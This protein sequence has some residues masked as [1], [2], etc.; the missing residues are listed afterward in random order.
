[1]IF[2]F[3]HRKLHFHGLIREVG[4]WFLVAALLSLFAAPFEPVATAQEPKPTERVY[5][6][7]QY[8][9]EK[10][11]EDMHAYESARLPVLAGFVNAKANTLRDY[12]NPHYQF[13]IDVIGQGSDHTLV[14]VSAKITAWYSANETTRS[15]YALIPSNGRLEE[16]LLDHLSVF[17]ETGSSQHS[18]EQDPIPATAPVTMASKPSLPAT[19]APNL[20]QPDPPNKAATAA[21]AFPAA[22]PIL[23]SAR[24]A[25]LASTIAATQSELE[26]VEQKEQESQKQIEELDTIARSRQHIVDFAIAKKAQTPVF[27]E[28]TEIS[29]VLFYVD[30]EDEFEVTEA[31][32]GWVHVRLENG[33]LGWLR[34]S[35]LELPGQPDVSDEYGAKN[36][37]AANEVIQPFTGEWAP[38]KGK[39]ALFVLAQPKGTIS[40][41]LLAQSQLEFATQAI[42]GVVVV[43]A[44][45]K[46][47]VAA[48]TLPEIRRWQEG[49][50]T[51]K[52]F[53]EHCSFDPPGSFH[54][55]PKN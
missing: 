53:F 21:G 12:G 39:T 2:S 52:L 22:D 45:D 35:E 7:P 34:I 13:E 10:A 50:I 9:V 43:F 17:L 42:D 48:A 30:S 38:L 14:Q 44:G 26:A 5:N 37:S 32:E 15:Q 3:P 46:Q 20:L 40:T 6:H 24:P 51:D 49:R 47:G 31:R 11:L 28:A 54:N 4:H 36:F 25:T 27:S 55:N 8:E 33:A 29:K 18:P 16:D 19:K 41:D 23:I 1:M